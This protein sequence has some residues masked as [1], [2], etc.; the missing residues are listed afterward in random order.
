MA[1]PKTKYDR[2]LRI[3]GELG[4]SALET[5]S[6]CLLNCGPTGSEALKNLVIGGIGSITIVDGSKVEIGDLGNN[7]MVDAKSVGQS[8]AKTVCGFLQELN[9]S[10]KANFVEENPDTLISTDPSFFSQ[11]TLVIATQVHYVED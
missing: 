10:V 4:Q 1:E 2:Q 9:D 5:A 3:W 8:R 7:F 11:F 6:I